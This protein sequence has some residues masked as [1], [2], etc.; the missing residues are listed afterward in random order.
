MKKL[1][2]YVFL[3]FFVSLTYSQEN[4]EKKKKD[5]WHATLNLGM[6]YYSGNVNKFNFKTSGNIS[7]VDS[8]FE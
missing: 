7:H 1:L 5:V 2:L 8:T 6:S 3:L 4:P